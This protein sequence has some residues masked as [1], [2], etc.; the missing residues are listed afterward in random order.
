MINQITYPFILPDLPYEKSALL[1]HISEEALDFHHGKHHNAYVVNLNKLLENLP[2]IAQLSLEEIMLKCYHDSNMA[3]IFNNAA[4][5]WNHSFYWHCMKPNGGGEPSE[6]LKSAIV[7]NFGSFDK[8]V[9]NFKQAAVSQFGSGWAWLV[10]NADGKLE[11][12]KTSN[13]ACPI[14]EGKV[15]L[16]TCDVWEHAYYI[17]YR[18][19]RPDY[20]SV[21]M[22]ELVNW[23]FVEKQLY[24][25]L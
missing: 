4:Q 1:P 2:E 5:I 7:E 18:N 20:V 13:A 3:G 15:P 9:E 25:P 6:K 24:N 21:F 10:K 17:D 12:V 8:F 22:N 16:L 14:V 11:I 19:R 23:D